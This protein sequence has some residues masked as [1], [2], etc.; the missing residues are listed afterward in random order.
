[1]EYFHPKTKEIPLFNPKTQTVEA[2]N[3]V[4]QLKKEP[5]SVSLWD[6]ISIPKQQTLLQEALKV[7]GQSV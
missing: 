2:L 5:T 3:M 7:E 1:M 6:I 4:E